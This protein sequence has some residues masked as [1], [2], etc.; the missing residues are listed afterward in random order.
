MAQPGAPSLSLQETVLQAGM[1]VPAA[2]LLSPEEINTGLS[3][4]TGP[5]GSVGVSAK[6]KQTKT[7]PKQINT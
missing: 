3:Q 4:R 6:K 1:G 2:C 7:K 5:V